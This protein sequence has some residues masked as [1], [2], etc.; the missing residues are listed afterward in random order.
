ME[1]FAIRP[2]HLKLQ[3]GFDEYDVSNGLAHVTGSIE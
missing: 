1:S 2:E 3:G